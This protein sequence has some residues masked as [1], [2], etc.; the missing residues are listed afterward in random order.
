MVTSTTAGQMSK[1]WGDDRAALGGCVFNFLKGKF[2]NNIQRQNDVVT[3][4][5]SELSLV[6]HNTQYFHYMFFFFFFLGEGFLLARELLLQ[7]ESIKC[8]LI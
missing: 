7:Y 5:F 3:I 6:C 8:L 2:R 1:L 4:R